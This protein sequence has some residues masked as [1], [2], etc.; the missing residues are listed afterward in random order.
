MKRGK[1]HEKNTFKKIV[2]EKCI[3]DAFKYL[4]E[5]QSSGEKQKLIKHSHLV[6]LDYLLPELKLTIPEKERKKYFQ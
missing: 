5:K 3:V 1:K 4:W 6:M 2:K